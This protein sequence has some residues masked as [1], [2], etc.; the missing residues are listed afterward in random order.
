MQVA[1]IIAEWNPLHRGHLLPLREARRRGATHIVAILSGNYVQRG[2]PALCPWPYRAAAALHSGVDLVLQLPLPYATATAEHFA[3]G[4]VASLAALGCVDMLVFGSECGDLPALQAVAAVLQSPALPTALAPHLAAGLPF[5]AARQAAVAQLLGSGPAALLSFPNN[6]LAIEYLRALA[7]LGS[8]IAPLTLP[9]QGA[10][11]DSLCG[12]AGLPSASL[13]RQRYRD[14]EDITPWLPP[15]MARQLRRA[16]EQGAVPERDLWQRAMLARLRTMEE[17]ELAALPDVTEGLEHRLYRAARAARSVEE[18]LAL[19]KAKRYSHARLRRI[20]LAAMLGLPRGLSAAP[21]PYLRV[22]GFTPRGA[23]IL[24]AAKRE[25]T[26]PLS[27]SLAE[28]SAVGEAAARFA[29]LEARAGDLYHAFTPGV[30]PCGGEYTTPVIKV[31]FAPEPVG[32][33]A[34]F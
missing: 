21:P 22:L 23:E 34:P 18:L 33:A 26:L 32:G 2:E 4:A 20:L 8:D 1:G 11:H 28:L 25:R 30:A 17:A 10:A 16:G 12:E 29:A 5:A 19:A 9:R 27:A 14:G 24:A 3:G 6:I 15:A 7:R 13:L 31:G